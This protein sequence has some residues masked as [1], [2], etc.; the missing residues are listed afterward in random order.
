MLKDTLRSAVRWVFRNYV[1]TV[2]Y[3]LAQG[4]KRRGGLGFLKRQALSPEEQF[5]LR[6]DL[7]GKT[8]YDVGAWEGIFTLF[9]ARAVGPQG[10]VICFEPNPSCWQ[11]VEAN[12]QLNSFKNVTIQKV[13]LGSERGQ[14]TLVFSASSLGVGSLDS[15]IQ[16][17][18]RRER[19]SHTIQ[20]TIDTLDALVAEARLPSPDLVKIDV[21]GFEYQ[22]LLGMQEIL[23]SSRPQLYIEIH[24][25]TTEQKQ[26]NVQ[27]VIQVL[28]ATGY[29]IHHIESNTEVT[30][31]NS[32]VASV[33]HIFA[34]SGS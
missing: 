3:G 2:R 22:V 25:S 8:V 27:R 5:L 11:R 10:Q 33:G 12:L 29:H 30:I 34:T 1:Y 13:A 6:L 28:A 7:T 32:H 4:L 21:E 31:A 16:A 19:G 24:G 9:F 15:A 18:L 20:V 26:A 14:G 17:N 23:R